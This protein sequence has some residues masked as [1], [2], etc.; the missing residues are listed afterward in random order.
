[1]LYAAICA[2]YGVASPFLPAFVNERGVPPEE[3]GMVLAAGTAI[4]L[5]AAPVAARIGDRLRALRAVLVVCIALLHAAFLAPMPVLADALSLGAASR[6]RFE[7]GRV[8][9]AGSA[10]FIAGTLVSGQL[11]AGHGLDAIVWS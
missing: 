10:A 9:G 7:Y 3:L 4:R 5:V 11:V 2:A 6:Q 8:R 1:M